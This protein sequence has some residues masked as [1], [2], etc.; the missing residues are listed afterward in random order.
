MAEKETSTSR[1]R[2]WI[3][4]KVK[5]PEAAA[6]KLYAALGEQGGDRWVVVRTDIVD[7]DYNVMVPVDAQDK[8]ALDEVHEKV[9]KEIGSTDTLMIQVSKHIPF[10]PHVAHGFVDPGEAAVKAFEGPK[11]KEVGRLGHSPGYNA[12]G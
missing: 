10:P 9:Q 11:G 2:A 3:L 4:V 1:V 12:W 5:S 8:A 6:R 7:Y